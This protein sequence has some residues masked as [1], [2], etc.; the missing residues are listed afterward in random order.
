MKFL[1]KN[2]VKKGIKEQEKEGLNCFKFDAK[3]NTLNLNKGV[4]A[5]DARNALTIIAKSLE[6]SG[7]SFTKE[8]Q[9]KFVNEWMKKFNY[10]DTQL[11]LKDGDTELAT[12]E[13][14]IFKKANIVTKK[15]NRVRKLVA[16]EQLTKQIN[17][18]NK[19]IVC[20]TTIQLRR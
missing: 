13:M 11:L 5:K 19:I 2:S 12:A 18:Q 17:K 6:Y 16:Y 9:A 4:K 1:Q 14:E 20:I 7:E 3:G 8:E 15:G 10:A